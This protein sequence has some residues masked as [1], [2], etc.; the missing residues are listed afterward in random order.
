MTRD[1]FINKL[2]K[3][4]GLSKDDK[5]AVCQYFID[6]Y[7]INFHGFFV[8]MPMKIADGGSDEAVNKGF[9]SLQSRI[10]EF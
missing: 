4:D 3:S 1:D 5:L 2:S 8:H 10:N 6:N 7:P 9:T